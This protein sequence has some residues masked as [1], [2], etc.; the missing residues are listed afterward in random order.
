[1]STRGLIGFR[2]NGKDFV[3]YNHFDSYPTVLGQKIFV[4]CRKYTLDEM[5]AA[6]SRFKIV[7]EDKAPTEA[8][9]KKA[10]PSL[11]ITDRTL[12]EALAAYQAPKEARKLTSWYSLLSPYQ[13]SLDF[14]LDGFSFWP[15]YD[16]F[17]YGSTCGWAYIIDCDT[18]CLEIYTRNYR[19]SANDAGSRQGSPVMKREGRY[20]TTPDADG[21]YSINLIAEIPLDEIR[22][23]PEESVIA[24]CERLKR[25]Y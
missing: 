9:L 5:R 2:L 7:D 13:G 12:E 25:L 10:W 8:Q 18:G 23:M 21:D 15:D 20:A 16:G 6:V 19:E 17:Q 22:L 3:Q 14:W 4:V 24:Y 1:M 11:G